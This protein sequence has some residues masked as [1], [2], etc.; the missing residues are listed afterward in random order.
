M[1]VIFVPEVT[2]FILPFSMIV[3][4]CNFISQDCEKVLL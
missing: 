2:V 1:N 3:P 4:I